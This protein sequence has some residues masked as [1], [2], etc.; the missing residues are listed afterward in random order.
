MSKQTINLGIAPNTY[1]GDRLRT[2]FAKVNNNFNELYALPVITDINQLTDNTSIL[3][4]GQWDDL[5]NKPPL[6]NVAF[7]GS[8]YDL[9]DYP[10]IANFNISFY[11][12]GKPYYGEVVFRYI[13][14]QTIT[15]RENFAGSLAKT[16]ITPITQSVFDIKKNGT[17]IGTITFQPSSANGVF[18]G[19]P[20]TLNSGDIIEV[21]SPQTQDSALSDIVVTISALRG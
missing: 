10:E 5:L 13:V 11:V 7:T 2:A 12:D 20:G 17:Q 18:S 14:P 8:F 21:Y 6:A 16:D 19:S 9:I 3:F 1:T 4:S 15:I